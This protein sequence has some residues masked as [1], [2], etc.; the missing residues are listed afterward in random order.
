[1][2]IPVLFGRLRVKS[3]ALGAPP[4][5]APRPAR[6]AISGRNVAGRLEAPPTGRWRSPSAEVTLQAGRQGT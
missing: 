1:M 4:G 2:R 6:T 3:M 5:R